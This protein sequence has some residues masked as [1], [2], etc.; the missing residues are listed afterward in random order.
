VPPAGVLL[1]RVVIVVAIYNLQYNS[2]NNK[3]LA[4]TLISSILA[5][6][7]TSNWYFEVKLLVPIKF[8]VNK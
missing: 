2:S 5:A 8:N 4:T 1:N 3:D 7:D 6:L